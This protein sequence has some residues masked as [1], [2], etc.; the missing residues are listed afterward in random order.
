VSASQTT[1]RITLLCEHCGEVA[2]IE[3][4][5]EQM[6][7]WLLVLGSSVAAG[8]DPM[9]DALQQALARRYGEG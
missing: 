7:R 5:D 6:R 9:P 8:L 4:D 2:R 1:H 3:L